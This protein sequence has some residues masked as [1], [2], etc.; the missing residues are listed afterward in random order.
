MV[1]TLFEF[2]ATLEKRQLFGP[3]LDFLAVFRIATGIGSVA[4]DEK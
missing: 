3:N 4:L 2:F 1:K